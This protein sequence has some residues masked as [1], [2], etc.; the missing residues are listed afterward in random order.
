[1]PATGSSKRRCV[2]TATPSRTASARTLS[3]S[4]LRASISV[5]SSVGTTVI[6]GNAATAMGQTW[7]SS[8]L[9]PRRRASEMA[10]ERA[11]AEQSLKSVP[12][13]ILAMFMVVLFRASG[14]LCPIGTA[15]P[16]PG[17]TRPRGITPLSSPGSPAF[18]PRGPRQHLRGS[19][20]FCEAPRNPLHKMQEPPL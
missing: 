9:A 10:C 8:M 16:V 7:T 3:S 13:R 18:I 2:W 19:R 6:S 15:S 14:S 17:P 4:R 11:S 1:M 12:T 5:L 20:S